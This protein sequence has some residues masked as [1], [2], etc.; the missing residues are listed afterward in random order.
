MSSLKKP[1]PIPNIWKDSTVYIIGGGPS[2]NDLDIDLLKGQ[3]VLGTNVSFKYYPWIDAVYFGDCSLYGRIHD[4]LLKFGGLKITSC[5]RAPDKGWPGVKR[6]CRGKPSGIDS[7][8][9]FRISWNGN[10][11][12]SAIN[13]AYW[14]GAKRIV[15]IGFDMRRVDK[16]KNFHND[17]QEEK[18]DFSPFKRYLRHF[19]QISHDANSLGLEILNASPVSLIEEFPIVKLEDTL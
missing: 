7:S 19:R 4:D 14:L 5:N 12:S 6:I 15:L 18:P 11:G 8:R 10:S 3:K 1:W 16:A 9:R 17:Y 13:V 2:I